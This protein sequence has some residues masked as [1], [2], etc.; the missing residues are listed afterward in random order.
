V[1][2]W[3]DDGNIAGKYISIDAFDVTGTVTQAYTRHQY[4]QSDVRLFYRGT[5]A[6]TSASAASGGSYK[7]A[8]TASAALDFAFTGAWVDLIATTGPG[9]GTADVSVDGGPA[10]TVHFSSDTTLY[11]QKV[12]STGKLAPGS[13]RIKIS[14][15]PDNPVGAHIDVDA[16]DILGM[17]AASNTASAGK[18]MWAEQRLKELSYLPGVV[19]GALDYKTKGAVIAFEKWEGLTRDGKI[20][21][22]VLSRLQT[23]SR[24][25]PS[26]VGTTNPWI[27]VNKAKQVLL[28]CKDG[29]VAITIPVSTGSA[30]V[31]IVTPS[32]TYT[33]FLKTL[34]TSPLYHPMA[35]TWAI[36]IHGYP[37][38][39]TYPASH[40]CVRTQNWDQDVIYPLVDLGTK[41]YVY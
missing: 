5:W 18:I 34:E 29:Q 22:T 15:S 7:R 35:I 17:L 12:W 33:V 31:G 23:A 26:K 8:D 39:P 28:F 2:I 27:E 13:H 1:K 30:S 11:Q 36:A 3:W 14:V 19:D 9:M 16:F 20:G 37:K 41:V 24:P 40:G 10:V 32:G 6:T 4:E 38:V 21:S 25:K